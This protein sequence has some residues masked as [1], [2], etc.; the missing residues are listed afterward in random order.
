[1]GNN[2]NQ[3]W[4]GRSTNPR[5]G[6]RTGKGGTKRAERGARGEKKGARGEGKDSERGGR[7]RRP[8]NEDDLPAWA[9]LLLG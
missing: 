6:A 7:A 5:E 1:M 8:Q 9:V 3:A 4:V 2:K